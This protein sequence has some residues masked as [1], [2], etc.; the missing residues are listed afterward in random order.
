MP[1]KELSRLKRRALPKYEPTMSNTII[2]HTETREQEDALK[3]FAKA[4][5]IKYEVTK[6]NPYSPD[7][8]AKIENSEQQFEEGD[9]TRIEK[10]DLKN[11]LGLE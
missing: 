8:L 10:K 9:F 1:S 11:F 6:E 7:F 2:F 3:A 5:K 4:L